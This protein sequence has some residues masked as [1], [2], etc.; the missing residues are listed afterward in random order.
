LNS[1]L[2]NIPVSLADYLQAKH[3]G[4]WNS[5]AK[6]LYGHAPVNPVPLARGEDL[7]HVANILH[8][9]TRHTFLQ[10]RGYG[11]DAYQTVK[12]K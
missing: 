2:P 7:T 6:G 3:M 10:E 8:P 5:T 9:T 12:R 1:N 4:Q 11:Y